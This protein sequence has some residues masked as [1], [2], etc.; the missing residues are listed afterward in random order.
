MLRVVA[1]NWSKQDHGLIFMVR[2]IVR[3]G[4]ATVTC[5]M[6]RVHRAFPNITPGESVALSIDVSIDRD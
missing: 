1:G 4:L 2:C 3:C 5:F 6:F